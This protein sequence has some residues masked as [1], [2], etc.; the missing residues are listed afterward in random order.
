MDLRT[1]SPAA[2]RRTRPRSLRRQILAR[3]ASSRADDDDRLRL[4]PASPACNGKAGKKESTGRRPNRPYPPYAKPSSNSSFDQG[5]SDV[6]IVKG[7]FATSGGASE[8][9]KVVLGSRLIKSRSEERRV[10]KDRRA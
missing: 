7:G 8:S 1:G 2:E 6:R 4:P 3:S 5:H 10:G 9:A